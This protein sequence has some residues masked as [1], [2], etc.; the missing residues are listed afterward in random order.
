MS[1]TSDPNT[2]TGPTGPLDS[3]GSGLD[4]T[5]PFDNPIEVVPAV[6]ALTASTFTVL[7]YE[8]NYGWS[9]PN[10]PWSPIPMSVAQPNSVVA[11][12]LLSRE[13]LIT[14][15]V[16]VW[17]NAA[18]LAVRGVWGDTDMLARIKAILQGTATADT[19]PS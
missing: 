11:T 3:S 12:V 18:Y 15:R 9:D 16:V 17:Q 7:H 2:P 10:I 1:G 14:Q 4:V 19:M 6:P 5:T 13:P 8:E